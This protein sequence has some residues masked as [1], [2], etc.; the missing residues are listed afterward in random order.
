MTCTHC[1]GADQLFDLKGAQK[2]LKKF[3]KKGPEK[4]TKKLIE[5]LSEGNEFCEKSLLDIG[6]GIGA[7]QWEFLNKGGLHST[8]VDASNNYQKVAK[9]HAEQIG[10][11]DRV[12]FVFGDFVDKSK[13]I[14]QRDFVTMDKVLCCY[15]DYRSLLEAALKK[16]KEGIAISYPVQGIVPRLFVMVENTYFKLRKIAFRTYLHSPTEIEERIKS[17]GFEITHKSISYPWHIQV[18]RR[19]S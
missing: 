8:G 9:S 15:P 16:C 17:H 6:G 5:Q 19:S 3:K 1:C 12:S 18:Y 10:F 11:A 14:P 7:I 2:K 4:V 13:E